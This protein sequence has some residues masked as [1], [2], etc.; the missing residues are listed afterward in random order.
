MKSVY[1]LRS[2]T[3]VV[4][5][6][7]SLQVNAQA[8]VANPT[9]PFWRINGNAAAA[10]NFIGTTNAQPFRVF[11]NNVERMRFNPVDGEIVAGA[12]ASPYA[13]DFFSAVS[14]LA[15]PF[16]LNGYSAQNGSGTW[17]EILAGS[18]TNFSAVQGVYTG[19]GAGAGVLGN[20]GGTSTA[21]NRAGVYGVMTAPAA[22]GG[23]GV[24]GFNQAATGNQHMGVLGSY[25]FTAFGIGVYGIGFGGGIIPGNNDIGVVGWRANNQNYSGYFNGNHVVA[26]GTKTASVPTTKGNQ[27]LYVMESPEVWF[28]DFGTAKLVN[29]EAKV[30]LDDLFLETVLIDAQHPMHVFVQVNG[31]CNDVYVEKGKDGFTVKEKSN[32]QSN[33]EF[34]YRVVAKR[35][36]F[37]DHRFGNDPVWG[38]GNTTAFSQRAPARPI[39]YDEAVKHFEE[40]RKNWKPTPMPEGFEYIKESEAAT[41]KKKEP[42]KNTPNREVPKG[43]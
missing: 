23:V 8:E 12:L 40:M 30:K 22:N 38:P 2:L 10:T 9:S 18:T 27:L 41:S 14:S 6:T 13:G 20:F 21:I 31:E 3:L 1:L 11:C 37:P 35:L 33:V 16:A 19:S 32:G 26:N 7:F 34:S 24:Y 29:G 42:I 5:C 43:Q 36:H 4:F 39:D 15:L 17:G 25:S 28:E